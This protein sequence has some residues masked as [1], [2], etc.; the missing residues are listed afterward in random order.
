MKT[1]KPTSIELAE[2][3]RAEKLQSIFIDTILKLKT[4]TE[5]IANNKIIVS[6]GISINCNLTTKPLKNEK[7]KIN[8]SINVIAPN[9]FGK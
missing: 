7:M 5:S 3:K 4:V 1:K 9:T 6:K 8:F 2:L